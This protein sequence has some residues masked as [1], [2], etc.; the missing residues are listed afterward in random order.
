MDDF[1]VAGSLLQHLETF[2]DQF[3]RA[4]AG[5]RFDAANTCRGGTFAD[6]DERADI[7][8][9]VKMCAAA[10]F[11]GIF[12]LMFDSRSGMND[13]HFSRHVRASRGNRDRADGLAVFLAEQSHRAFGNRVFAGLVSC[14]ITS[15][16]AA[17]ASLTIFSTRSICSGV[18]ASGWVKSKR[19]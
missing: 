10:Q 2:G 1:N 13:R 12:L 4:A 17:T 11:V 6:D 19:R 8:S 5:H 7:G 9:A 14:G 15:I 16:S 3:I 18:M